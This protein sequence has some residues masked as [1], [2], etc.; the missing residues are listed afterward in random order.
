MPVLFDKLIHGINAIK[1]TCCPVLS[2]F[3]R[4]NKN[5]KQR[6]IIYTKII[7]DFCNSKSCIHRLTFI[8]ITNEILNDFSTD[9]FKVLIYT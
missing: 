9:F 5:E 1:L 7:Q 3:F 2:T 8:K 4:N 6:T